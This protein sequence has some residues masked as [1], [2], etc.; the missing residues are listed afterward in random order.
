[1]KI[2]LEKLR[3]ASM[4]LALSTERERNLFLKNFAE[5]LKK[6]KHMI[7]RA[8]V[9]DVEKARK[10]KLPV[11][12]IQRL[13]LD[14]G[15]IE[16]MYDKLKSVI[17]LSS[18]VGEVIGPTVRRRGLLVQ[19]RR[20]PLGV[21]LV[22]YESRPE[23]TVD[24]AALCIKSGNVAILKG[25]SEAKFTNQ[26]LHRCIT[27][28]LFRTALSRDSVTFI[29]GRKEVKQLLRRNDRIDLVIARGGYKMVKSIMNEST[30]AVLAHA[31]GGAR[32]Y[33]D[34]S[35]DQ[36][37]AARVIVNSKTDKAA[38]CNSLDTILVHRSI[39]HTFLPKIAQLLNSHGVS[40]LGGRDAARIIKVKHITEKEWHKEFLGLQVGVK[41][42]KDVTDATA[43]MNKYGK[44]HSEGIVARDVQKIRQFTRSVDAAG[45]FVNCSTRL[46]DG[47]VFGLGSEMGI[48]TGKLHARGPVGLK[49]LT[50]YTWEVYGK[51]NIRE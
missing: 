33:V 27:D 21:L 49:E 30:I 31:A 15:G 24:V 28:S 13:I 38:A 51:G 43:F 48:S 2:N 5:I 8:N 44:R 9:K 22:I 17:N 6:R 29:A 42:V 11:A 20:V 7:I 25:G 50:T 41:I 32:I 4:A 40:L 23:V 10:N 34:K 26:V 16:T 39:A 3:T 1:M 46:H 35:A 19:K 14:A 37:I 36:S 45:L 12:F 18:G 47:Y